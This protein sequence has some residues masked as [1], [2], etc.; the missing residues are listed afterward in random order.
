ME[1]PLNQGTK[2]KSEK[3]EK[4]KLQPKNRLQKR[5]SCSKNRLLENS[6]LAKKASCL[7]VIN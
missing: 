3:K 5:L 1:K 7:C 4:R 2:K 6:L